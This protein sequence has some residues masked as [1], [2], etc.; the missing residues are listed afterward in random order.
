M[1]DRAV[2]SGLGVDLELVH[3]EP[4]RAQELHARLDQARMAREPSEDLVPSLDVKCRARGV[5]A[6]LAHHLGPIRRQQ[7]GDLA[8]EEVHLLGREQARQEYES[9][10]LEFGD[11]GWR[12]LHG[13]SPQQPNFAR[14]WPSPAGDTRG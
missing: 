3:V 7:A 2:E 1:Q 6:L 11:L 13:R 14:L 8:I 5:R 4:V 12:E 9:L 10:L